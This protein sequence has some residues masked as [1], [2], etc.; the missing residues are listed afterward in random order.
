VDKIQAKFNQK[1][2]REAPKGPVHK[3]TMSYC[4]NEIRPLL[5]L[6]KNQDTSQAIKMS[7]KRFLIISLISTFEFYFKYM[8]SNYVDSN[9]VDLTNLFS[10][11]I[12]FKLSDLDATLKDNIITKGNILLSSV[13]F[14]DLHQINSFISNLLEID[15]FK[16]LY[17]ENTNDKC[18]MMIRNAPPIDINYE[19]LFK[20]YEL[21]NKIVH[22][23]SDVPYSY[24][25]ILNLW[26]NAMN[27]FEIANTIFMLPEQLQQF[28]L[29]YRRKTSKK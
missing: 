21:R 27:I 3:Q 2:A 29:L 17:S 7:L 5:D 9:N 8:A 16:Y 24:T 19:H 20:A 1:T 13:K 12:C 4:E 15:L 22:G 14:S 18:K 6:L 25:H 11:E 10:D 28:R 26:D 23:L